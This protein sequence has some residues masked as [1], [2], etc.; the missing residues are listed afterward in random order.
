MFENVRSGDDFQIVT[1]IAQRLTVIQIKYYIPFEMILIAFFQSYYL[2]NDILKGSYCSLNGLTN[3][4]QCTYIVVFMY[5]I[6]INI[7]RFLN[8]CS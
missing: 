1:S 5:D 4:C 2:R 7:R 3:H 8:V 6:C